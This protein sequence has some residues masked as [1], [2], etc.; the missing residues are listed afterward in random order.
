MPIALTFR[1]ISVNVKQ[2]LQFTLLITLS[3][4]YRSLPDISTN[5]YHQ[6]LNDIVNNYKNE[7][8]CDE[9]KLL[10]YYVNIV[11]TDEYPQYKG[12]IMWHYQQMQQDNCEQCSYLIPFNDHH[13]C[14]F[15]GRGHSIDFSL[16]IHNHILNCL[17]KDGII[18]DSDYINLRIHLPFRGDNTGMCFYPGALFLVLFS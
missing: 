12:V 8:R 16:R 18:N 15:F 7:L 10:L 11:L 6:Y 2:F 13:Q 4:I 1:L 17:H 14:Y 9:E 3:L 5:L